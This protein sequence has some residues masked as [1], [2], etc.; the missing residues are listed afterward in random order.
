MASDDS[1]DVFLNGQLID[2]DPEPDYEFTYW[3][4]DVEVPLKFFKAGRN[5][6]AVVVR[7]KQGSSDLYF[8]LE[9]SAEVPLPPKPKTDKK[10]V[11]SQPAP[12][13]DKP[14]AAVDN[15]PPTN[16]TIDKEKKTVTIKCLVAPRKLPNLNEVYPIEVIATYP[17]SKGQKAHEAVVTFEG[18]KPSDIHRALEQLGLKPGKPARGN[19]MAEGPEVKIFL[20]VS[21][22]EAKPRKIPI[23]Q[24]LVDR[25]TGKPLP[26]LKWLFT[27]SAA[28]QPDPEKDDKVYGADLSGTLIAL[29][30][31]TDDC[32]FQ[33]N[34]TLKEEMVLKLETNKDILPK[35]GMAVRLIIEVK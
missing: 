9:L 15:K 27:G 31:V 34:L 20:E 3:N 5:M 21:M 25:K 7:N 29:F 32:V 8:D 11:A 16:L 12:K 22:G 13:N 19:G 35:E 24:T 1:A 17:A 18:V 33:T 30:P 28:K 6:L 26:A 4:R 14:V 23:E 2:K 10:P